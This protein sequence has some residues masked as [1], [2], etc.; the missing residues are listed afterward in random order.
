MAK[1]SNKTSDKPSAE[2]PPKGDG[3]SGQDATAKSEQDVMAQMLAT[4]SPPETIYETSDMTPQEIAEENANFKAMGLSIIILDVSRFS[5][6]LDR[7][8]DG[9]YKRSTIRKPAAK[10]T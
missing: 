3:E 4:P 5:A 9:S 2:T 1:K 7:Q 8:D 6:K 10:A